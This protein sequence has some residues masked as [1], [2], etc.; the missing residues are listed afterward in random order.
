V[1]RFVRLRVCGGD[2]RLLTARYQSRYDL[3]T[4][5]AASALFKAVW[6]RYQPRGNGYLWPV[7]TGSRRLS[8]ARRGDHCGWRWRRIGGAW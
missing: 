7:R 1:S 6:G 5:L 3:M 8:E 4:R 2:A